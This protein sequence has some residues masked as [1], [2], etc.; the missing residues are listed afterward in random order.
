MRWTLWV[1]L[2]LV[3][4]GAWIVHVVV[5]NLCWSGLIRAPWSA[6][7]SSAIGAAVFVLVAGVAEITPR[8]GA[9][10]WARWALW[11]ALWLTMTDGSV[12][13]RP[14]DDAGR[15]V[16]WMVILGPPM[17]AVLVIAWRLWPKR[18]AARARPLNLGD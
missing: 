4:L 10:A 15:A 8:G 12:R 14:D 16:A 9:R 1:K 13:V 6:A 3:A 5:G 17:V 7:T 2:A 11:S 18:R